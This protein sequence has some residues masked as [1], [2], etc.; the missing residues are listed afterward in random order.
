VPVPERVT[1]A[2]PHFRHGAAIEPTLAGALAQE[3]VDVDVI[4]VD[5]VSGDHTRAELNRFA[6][7]RVQIL[8]QPANQGPSAARERATERAE[9]AWVAYLDQDDR[10]RP[11]HLA[12][13]LEAARSAGAR[14]AAGGVRY[15]DDA[16]TVIHEPPALPGRLTADFLH[17]GM[18]LVTPS[19]LVVERELALATGWDDHLRVLADWDFAL[20]LADRAPGAAGAGRTVDYVRHEGAWSRNAVERAT[21]ELA[22]L[23]RKRRA[24]GA[25][26]VDTAYL[27]R[28]LAYETRAGGARR[29]SASQFLRAA[30]AGRDPTQAVRAVKVLLR[31]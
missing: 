14:W 29:T 18:E 31:G 3:A 1:V 10:W 4:V 21:A 17:T 8:D 30:I 13:C 23:Q 2:I 19:A 11:D 6:G 27:H 5:D 20:R 9:G 12:T 24:A 15:V 7:D 16:G 26:P 28:W 22:V 25:P